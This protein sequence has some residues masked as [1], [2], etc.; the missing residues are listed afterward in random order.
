MLTVKFRSRMAPCDT[1]TVHDRAT[2]REY[3]VDIRRG[4]DFPKYSW[5]EAGPL[6]LIVRNAVIRHLI[7]EADDSRAYIREMQRNTPDID[8]GIRMPK[9][10]I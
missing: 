9:G 4:H 10:G 7:A 6:P 2:M 8:L 5:R 3:T 1:Y